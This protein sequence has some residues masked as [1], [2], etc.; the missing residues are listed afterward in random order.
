MDL[1]FTKPN[2]FW[3][4]SANI[5]WVS[6]IYNLLVLVV[7]VELYSSVISRPP[8]STSLG[9]LLK[10][11]IIIAFFS[12]STKLCQWRPLGLKKLSR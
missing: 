5:Y 6:S 1:N 10:I 9:N 3:K 8:V 11:Q 7:L 2:I 12:P 4:L